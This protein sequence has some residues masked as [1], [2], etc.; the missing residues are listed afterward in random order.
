MLSLRDYQREACDAFYEYIKSGGISPVVELGTGL[1]KSLINATVCKDLTEQYG[2]RILCLAHV[3]GLVGQNAQELLNIW[4]NAPVGVNSD[5]LGRR[6]WRSQI[7]FAGVHSIHRNVD[8][9]GPVDLVIV[10]EA[11]MIPKKQ[12]GMYRRVIDQLRDI[13]HDL[14]LAALSATPYR[15]DSGRIDEGE[16]ALFEKTV[17]KYGIAEGIREG[18][19]VPLISKAMVAEID[20][21]GVHTLGGDFVTGELEQAAMAG[22]N[23]ARAV[24]EMIH[25][26]RDRRSWVA[27]CTGVEHSDAVA[28][29]L[30]Q[31]G[32]KAASV[33]TKTKDRDRIEAEAAFRA[34]RLRCLVNVNIY[35]VGSNFPNIDMISML[36][37]SHSPGLVSQQ[38]GRGT[39]LID[40][41]IGKLPTVEERLAAIA[42]SSKPDCLVLDFAGN[43]KRHGPIDRMTAPERKKRKRTKEPT[44]VRI[45]PEC[46]G[47]EPIEAKECSQCGHVWERAP[48]QAANHDGEADGQ[49]VVLSDQEK[50]IWVKVTGW[51]FSIH[52]KAGKPP[53]LQVKYRWGINGTV[54]EWW[55]FEHG[56]K[57]T[58]KAKRRWSELRPYDFEQIF[59]PQTTQEAFENAVRCLACPAEMMI[60]R[61]GKYF[62]VV[63]LRAAPEMAVAS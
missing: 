4:P 10:D 16:D 43:L 24:D 25:Y 51:H 61:T 7:L 30:R 44:L 22:N 55:C 33:T 6:D 13:T 52:Q 23:V 34:G 63:K 62:E 41:D 45:C 27:F 29:R 5:K 15:M 14:R 59:V 49:V 11:Q 32:I 20:T 18:Y 3:P 53:S 28:E 46:N 54:S 60:R 38:L 42:E 48:R 40:G 26:G 57:A 21:T 17:Y 56:D 36:R 31:R 37:P 35:S 50:P 58:A 1:G 19:L 9:I 8:L 39:R 12:V 47:I 2:A